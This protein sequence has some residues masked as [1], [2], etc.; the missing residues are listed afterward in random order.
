MTKQICQSCL[1]TRVMPLVVSLPVFEAKG[2]QASN[3]Y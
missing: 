3:N 2:K 1:M